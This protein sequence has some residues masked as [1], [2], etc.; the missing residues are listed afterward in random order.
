MKAAEAMG[1][2]RSRKA[3]LDLSAGR[4]KRPRWFA[5]IVA[6]AAGLLQPSCFPIIVH[7]ETDSS[8]LV[9]VRGDGWAYD[10]GQA[11]GHGLRLAFSAGNARRSRAVEIPV[12][13]VPLP[14][15]L[16]HPGQGYDGTPSLSVQIDAEGEDIWFDPLRVVMRPSETERATALH[17]ERC[18]D[19][20]KSPERL[21]VERGVCV[22]WWFATLPSNF[23]LVLDSFD[24]DGRPIPAAVL[25]FQA[26]SRSRWRLG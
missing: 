17:A 1:G 16:P 10:Q 21:R 13:I 15:P 3:R 14:I 11:V 7:S 12:I 2:R 18:G 20:T 23:T 4:V 22:R 19:T 5:A 25:T 6:I 9:S 8:R 24:R 26:E